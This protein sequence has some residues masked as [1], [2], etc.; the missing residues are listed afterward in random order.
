MI[1]KELTTHPLAYSVLLA[2]TVL[3]VLSFFAVW[4]EPMLERLVIA[5][6]AV[7]YFTWGVVTHYSKRQATGLLIQEYGLVS[8]LGALL[9]LMLTF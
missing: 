4:P 3:F 6:Y 5:A 9:L 2:G 8:L 1:K 7:F